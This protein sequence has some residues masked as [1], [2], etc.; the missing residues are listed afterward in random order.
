M[1]VVG[2]AEVLVTP[3][4]TGAQAKISKEIDRSAS[5]AGR[6]AG[7][8]M[9][10]GLAD[11]FKDE[12]KGFEAEVARLETAVTKSQDRVAA[13]KTKLTAAS[14]AESKALGDLRVAE[15]RLQEARDSSSAKASAV[16]TAEERVKTTRDRVSAATSKRETAERA[17]TKAHAELDSV[18]KRSTAASQNLETHLRNVG[19]ESATTER[20]VTR[21]GAALSR[22]SALNPFS[23]LSTSMHRDSDRISNDLTRMAQQAS[24]FGNGGG[25]AVARA[26]GLMTAGLTAVGPAVGAAGA[27]LIAG[28]GNAL[29]LA[30]SLTSLG[31]VAAL[32]PAGLISVGAG[33]GVLATA[34]LG[35][36]DAL[37]AVNDQ[38]SVF[39]ANPR[40]AA[41]AVQDATQAITVAEQ[42]ATRV[43][44]DSS[45]RVSD[46]KRS[47]QDAIAGAAQAEQDAAKT[48][49]QA[50]RRVSEAQQSLQDAVDAAARAQQDAAKASEQAAR[51]VQDAQRNLTDAVKAAA[52][53]EQDSS[54]AIV[55]ATRRVRDAKLD[56]QSTIESV[57]DAQKAAARAV[58]RAE[59]QEAS[60]ARDVTK[61][62]TELTQ[63][64]AAAAAQVSVVE[65]RL[66]DANL[67]ATD[68]AL[69]YQG[70]MA[71]YNNAQLDPGAGAGQLAQLQNNAEKARVA[72]VRA[73]QSVV[74]LRKEQAKALADAKTGGAAVLDAEQRLAD[75]QQ[76]QTNA[77]QD[78]QDAQQK[79]VRQQRDGA[80]QVA[81]AQETVADAVKAQKAAQTDAGTSAEQSARRVA[82][83]QQSV[84]DAV[85][86]QRGA[87][88]AA[89]R[90]A[91][92]GA[93]RVADAQQSV[94]DA[95]AAERDARAEAVKAGTDG[96]RRVA[97]AQQAVTDATRDAEQSQMDAARAVDQAYRNL[98]RVQLQQADS[99][100]QAGS[101][102]AQA[103]DKLTPSAQEAVRTLLTLRDT[104]DGVRRIAQE[105][106]FT[107][108]SAG[109]T[110]L[111]TTLL[112]QLKTGVGAIATAFNGSAKQLLTSVDSA[113]GG[114]VLNQLLQGVATSVTILNRAIDPIVQSF[115]TLGV[116]GMRYM[117]LL[118]QWVAD[119]AARFNN[120]IQDT[121]AD[122][123]LVGWIDAGIQG[124]QDL[125]SI[126][127]SVI[128]IFND[129]SRAAATGGAVA[130]LGGLA[131]GMRDLDA[132]MSGSD[133]QTTMS[134]IF[135]GAQQGAD[136]LLKA[137]GP[138]GAA[139][140]RGARAMAEF[141]RLGGE[142]AGTFVGGVFTALSDPSFG[143]GLTGFMVD[144]QHGAEAVAPL[145]PGLS[146]AF[147]RILTVL[148]P[149]VAQLG[150]TLVEV[151]TGIATAVGGILTV[152]QPTLKLIAGSPVAIGLM[153][154]AVAA[155]SA[156][157][158][159][160][161]V[162]GG[163]M[164]AW[165]VATTLATG[166]QKLLNQAL[167][168][169]PVGLVVTA[170]GLLVGALV[171]FFTE[172]EWGRNIVAAAWAGIQVAI[173]AVVSWWQTTVMP[174]LQVGLQI[175]GRAFTWLNE[176]VIQPVFR[177]IGA[178]ISWWWRSVVTPV[179]S[180]VVWYVRNILAPVYT[181]LWN[182]VVVPVFRGI[183][184]VISWVWTSIIRP[185]FSALVG[186]VRNVIAPA[187]GWLW[188][189]AV[190]PTFRGIGAVISWVWTSIIRPAF[191]AL[192]GFMRNVIAPA[193]GWLWH[194]VIEPGFRG[195][196]GAISWVWEHIISPAFN[197]LHD[198]ITKTIP[199]AFQ[200]GV[201][202]VKKWWDG[203]Q[204]IAK[205]PIRFVVNTVI[206][207]GLIG[208]FNT[209]AGFLPGVKKLDRVKLPDGFARGGILPGRS[210][211]RQGDDQL[212]QARRGEGITM[213]EVLADPYERARLLHMNAEARKGRSAAAARES[214]ASHGHADGAFAAGPP[215]GPSGGIWSALQQA[216][217]AAGHIYFPKR[218]FLGVDTEKAA[219]AWMGQSALDVRVGDGNPGIKQ[220]VP[221]G[222][223]GWGYYS[224]DTIWMQPG[225]PKSSGD[226]LGVLVHE[227]GHAL[228]LAHTALADTSSVMNPMQRGGNWPHPG[229]YSTLRSIWGNPGDG[230]KRYSASEVGID[231]GGMFN[232]LTALASL[233][234]AKF[235]AAFPA[236]GMLADVAIGTGKKLIDTARDWV[237]DRLGSVVGG[238]QQVITGAVDRAKVTAW[239]TEALIKKG[240]LNPANLISG[241]NRA[242]K[243]SGGNPNAV[244]GWDVNAKNGDPSRGLMQVIG[245]TFR[246]Y[247]EPG[248]GNVLDPVDNILASINYTR[249]RYGSLQAGWNLPGGYAVGGIVGSLL[250]ATRAR[251][252]QPR[253]SLA[254]A[255]FKYDQ[256]GVLSPGL[257]QVVN[258]TRKPEHIFTAGQSEA[259][260]Q[261]AAR[262]ARQ[263]AAGVHIDQVMLPQ[264]ASV[265]DLVDA[266]GFQQRVAARGGARR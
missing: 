164:N 155:L 77:V 114:G 200:T 170:V 53:A 71:A 37:K 121:A 105:N 210:T 204:D 213:T 33:A 133:F 248:H 118:A 216:A 62:Q 24:L 127:G 184:A 74:D 6:S 108:L 1:P 131:A 208:A 3:V 177:G 38:Q 252:A 138:I 135:A 186:F 157:V 13:G 75:A 239:M 173:G 10:T 266:L 7:A 21:L 81:T 54:D 182:N 194:N 83:A 95:V 185:A 99:A 39:V 96:A 226:K 4:F 183:G 15:L 93:R 264:R 196:G 198:A 128:G 251:P 140:E 19:N 111:V 64:R 76:S 230:V 225:G 50:A 49:E 22:I 201:A 179:F 119:V 163:I 69:A 156:T 241:V 14:A 246:Q 223:G 150:P 107:G 88:A 89:V 57:A 209:V 139:F 147:G 52:R 112:P 255:P 262:G 254:D 113:L 153:I 82:D 149:I 232:P 161:K 265:D 90:A 175:L 63:A 197:L 34:F 154:G 31:G 91:E 217:S 8:R 195:A 20:N 205:A 220:Y 46:A 9:G 160:L 100:A 168:D 25:K 165:T 259:L 56:L 79:V 94:T 243:E 30:S 98:E 188:H 169:N 143:A 85:D 66:Q 137:L 134:T 172:T 130:T 180:A 142:I 151:F 207:D 84:T 103:M 178:V 260:Q 28:A 120:W 92:D 253:G 42:N 11:G 73:Q 70:A 86:A 227:M 249:A 5:T 106:F 212:I 203:L 2:L 233:M 26:A 258:L 40:I 247:M 129:L 68:S 41:M 23:G 102:A 55:E 190:E 59:Q 145:M 162:V 181:W 144:L 231:A 116:V 257:S 47:L 124:L 60:T 29:T 192:V 61:A 148:G 214:F 72:N 158:V 263:R 152:L 229:D 228:S 97:D 215:G 261:L 167:K 238:A 122:G 125:W 236:G 237:G 146:D 17:L 193:V 206:N 101:K 16:A 80:R 171:W 110:N 191:S 35:V 245:A 43:Q 87:Q 211:W 27:G 132:A 235:R 219:K 242:F 44:V 78:R 109:A 136:G 250:G 224:G 234:E 18:Q 104:L 65:Q 32:I 221:G 126:A 67:A 202:A 141:L 256:G 58:Q 189:N 48:S 159:G 12:T 117:P 174:V 36:G 218:S 166:A 222:P 115:V 176:N 240:E 51:R 123:R 199:N 244:N 45:R 187:L